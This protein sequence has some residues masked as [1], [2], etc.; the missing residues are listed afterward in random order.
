RF[1]PRP[2]RNGSSFGED[3]LLV[4]AAELFFDLVREGFGQFDALSA[5][6]T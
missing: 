2:V 4:L 6:G 3:A 5:F 1:L